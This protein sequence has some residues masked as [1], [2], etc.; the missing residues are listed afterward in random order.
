MA[1]EQR[2]IKSPPMKFFST[3]EGINGACLPHLREQTLPRLCR[4]YAPLYMAQVI[5]I[6]RLFGNPSHTN[7]H[8]MARG[9]S[10]HISCTAYNTIPNMLHYRKKRTL[11]T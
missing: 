6:Y 5:G 3:S 10:V 1:M 2:A 11:A 4:V 9:I 8:N 7:R